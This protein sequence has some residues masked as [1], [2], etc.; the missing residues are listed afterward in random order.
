MTDP[1]RTKGRLAAA[2]ALLSALG[3]AAVAAIVLHRPEPRL[4][5]AMTGTGDA[6]HGAYV[7]VLGDCAACHTAPGGT[8]LTGG[9]PLET[10]MGVLY[11]SNITPA[12][13]TGIGRYTFVDFVRVMRYGVRPDGTRLYPAMPYTAYARMSDGDL[14][15]LYAYLRQDVVP[16]EQATRPSTMRWPFDMRWPLALWNLA[17]HHPAPFRPDPTRDAQWNRGAYL[18]TGPAHCGTCH[19]PR[20]LAFQEAGLDEHAQRFLSG[21]AFAGA[22]PVDLR[23]DGAVAGWPAAD[24]ATELKTGRNRASAV[25]GP[26]GEVVEHSTR[27]MSMADLDAVAVYLKSLSPASAGRPLRFAPS[28]ETMAAFMAARPAGRGARLY[29]DSCAACHRLSGLGEENTFPRLAGNPLVLERNPDSLIT[30]VLGGARMPSTAGAP[31]GLAMPPFGWRY[32]DADIAKLVTFI[33]TGWGN[34]APAVSEGEVR[35]VRRHLADT[36]AYTQP[37]SGQ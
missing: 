23:G 12:S 27:Y 19:T 25:S 20:G 7:A 4:A 5:M 24:I 21:S 2:G 28:G 15:D 1:A 6:R 34:N 37:Q 8:P 16:V 35:A 33:R 26:M 32:G 29:M 22:S 30:V 3:I 14:R 13:R 18:V 10:P 31:T 11:S 17:F 9:V 36:M